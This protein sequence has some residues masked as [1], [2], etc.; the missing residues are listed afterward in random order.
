MRIKYKCSFTPLESR[1]IANQVAVLL[2]SRDIK[3]QDIIGWRDINT[4]HFTIH[5]A[6]ELQQ[7][8]CLK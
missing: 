3:G 8:I 4:H 6:Y 7:G 2:E 5:S 1:D